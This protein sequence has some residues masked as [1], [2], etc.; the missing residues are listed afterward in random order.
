[1]ST[2]VKVVWLPDKGYL[3]QLKAR[4]HEF[5]SDATKTNKGLDLAATPHEIFLAGLAAC[6]AMTVEMFAASKGW[7]LQSV[8]VCVKED[9]VADPDEPSKKIPHI[10]ETLEIEGELSAEQLDKLKEIAKRC[11]VYKLFVGKKIVDCQVQLQQSKPS[12]V[13]ADGPEPSTADN[14]RQN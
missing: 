12:T 6:T 7:A 11:P 13:P 8:S 2:E 5:L 3:H 9:S 10:S 1:M 4:G 14:T